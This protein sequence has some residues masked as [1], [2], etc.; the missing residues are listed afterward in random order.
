MPDARPRIL[1]VADTHLGFDLPQRPRVRRRRRGPDFF[2]NFESA[3]RPALNGQCDLVVHGGDLLFRSRVRPWLVEKAVAPLLRVADH[4]VP[5]VVVP[6]NHE[7]S[8]IPFPLLSAHNNVHILDRPRTVRFELH[9]QAVSVSGFPCVRE[10]I[11]ERFGALVDATGWRNLPAT[12][13]LL[14]LHQTVEG[15]KVG[16]V[17]YTF[18][19]GADVIRG[20]DIPPSFAAVLAGHIHRHQVLRRDLAGRRLAAPVFYPGS[21]ERTSVAER[22][23]EK[24]YLTLDL[25]P[26][27]ERGGA[28]ESWTF[29]RLPARSMVDLPIRTTGVNP[30][31]LK[32]RLCDGLEKLDPDAVVRV[33]PQ[34]DVAPDQLPLFRAEALRAI[35]P[36]TM[37]VSLRWGADARTVP[38]VRARDR[39]DGSR[40][41]IAVQSRRT[42]TADHDPR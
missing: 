30:A 32:R 13:R 27:P 41:R 25:R 20:R 29:H 9:G 7:R 10:G 15:A 12:V 4:G 21:I 5:V 19:R 6:G 42:R 38:P 22:D 28:V 36:S 33:C 3:L 31:Q 18:R 14:C 17:D 16:P 23:E 24:G 1:L 34:G 8:R 26:G 39:P 37:S 2:R 11:R 35:A 40:L